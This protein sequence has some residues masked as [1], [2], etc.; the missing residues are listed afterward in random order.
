MGGVQRAL[1]LGYHNA[2]LEYKVQ[3]YGSYLYKV[4]NATYIVY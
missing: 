2:E 1:P 3:R 4:H